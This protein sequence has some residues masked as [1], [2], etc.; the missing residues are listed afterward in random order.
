MELAEDEIATPARVTLKTVAAVPSH[1]HPLAGLPQRNVGADRVDAPGN[2]VARHSRILNSRPEPF[3]YECVAVADTAGFHL[4]A[5]LP[6]S[7][8][9]SWALDDFKSSSWLA[10]LYGFHGEFLSMRLRVLA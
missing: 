8:L 6:A 4:E 10:D 3:L 9:W 7:R 1:S 2:F 5:H